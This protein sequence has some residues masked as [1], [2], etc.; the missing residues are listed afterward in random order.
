MGKKADEAMLL[1]DERDLLLPEVQ[2]VVASQSEENVVLHRGERELDDAL[3]PVRHYRTTAAELHLKVTGVGDRHVVFKIEGA[4][5][6][7]I[8]VEDSGA[9]AAGTEIS[10]MPVDLRSAAQE[11]SVIDE[12][13]AVVIEVVDI[14]LKAALAHS[15][16]QALRKRVA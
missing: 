10:G 12:E 3:H 15:R 1:A 14:D 7:L 9:E 8:A 2:R 11:S 13:F 5:P 6:L 4:I 16:D